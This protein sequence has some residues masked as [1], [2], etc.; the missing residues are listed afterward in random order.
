MRGPSPRALRQGASTRNASLSPPP[1][2]GAAPPAAP[3]PPP[4]RLRRLLAPELR[5]RLL[6]ELLGRAPRPCDVQRWWSCDD[7]T[8]RSWSKC[9]RGCAPQ[10]RG[11]APRPTAA[12]RDGQRDSG[13]RRFAG[14]CGSSSSKRRSA[15]RHRGRRRRAGASRRPPRR[16]TQPGRATTRRARTAASLAKRQGRHG[17]RNSL[18][19]TPRKL[20][21]GVRP[22]VSGRAAPWAARGGWAAKPA[23]RRP[24][25][26][27]KT[28]TGSR[29]RHAELARRAD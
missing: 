8:R 16:H 28:A 14:G 2:S 7:A 20:V 22:R 3:C 12:R 11:R 24:T 17:M 26:R 6:F 25:S 27:S 29:A 18:A 23:A 21:R 4:P 19:P 9:G 1:P 15:R 13:R 5:R 10:G